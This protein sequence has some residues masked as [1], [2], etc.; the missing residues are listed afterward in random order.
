MQAA[1][2]SQLHIS[3]AYIDQRHIW[4]LS[5]KLGND[6]FFQFFFLVFANFLPMKKILTIFSC[7]EL[8]LRSKSR[9]RILSSYTASVFKFLCACKVFHVCYVLNYLVKYSNSFFRSKSSEISRNLPILYFI[10]DMHYSK[11]LLNLSVFFLLSLFFFF[12]LS[13]I[14]SIF[15][16]VWTDAI[17]MVVS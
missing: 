7:S 5:N 8:Q 16:P 6:Y 2:D 13:E 10:H 3:V 15:T 11:K 12:W 9:L 17:P 14:Q 4:I 1:L